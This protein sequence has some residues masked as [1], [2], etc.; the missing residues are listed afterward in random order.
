MRNHLTAD[1]GETRDAT[2]DEKEA[3]FIESADIACEEPSVL[4]D[5]CGFGRI[6]Q[7]TMKN[8]GT[9]EPDQALLVDG[10]GL[11]SGGI[12]QTHSD[13]RKHLSN[14]AITR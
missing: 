9:F 13:T 11:F 14:G 7:I 8:I 2:F 10:N 6:V 3:V 4:E 5:F 12:G 1:F